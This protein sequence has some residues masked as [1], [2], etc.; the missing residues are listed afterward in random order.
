MKN[1][2]LL[3]K[4]MPF[5]LGHKA[6]IDFAAKQCDQLTVLVC[7][8]DQETMPGEL[9][10]QWIAETYVDQPQISVDL[11]HYKEAELPNSS[12]SSRTISK[13]W[14]HKLKILY[15][16]VNLFISSEPY[17]AYVAEY[18]GID[19]HVFDQDREQVPISA[20][21][22]RE[23][24]IQYWDFLPE[25]VKPHYHRKVVLLGTESTGKSTMAEKLAADFKQ[26][27]LRE[28]GRDLIPDSSDF[29]LEDLYRV[30]E[31]HQALLEAALAPLPALLIMDTDLHITQSY[32]QFSF[33][34]YL[35]LPEHYYA[36]QQAD[37]YLYLRMDVPFVQ[38]GSRMPE[39]DR[40]ALEAQHR[41]TIAHYQLPI[42]EIYGSWEAR[43]EQ[44]LAAIEKL[45]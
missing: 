34:Q 11:L 18:M 15:P 7:A 29:R 22:I 8:S 13:V 2:L 24:P 4:F 6:L 41:E 42:V 17:G 14:A 27:L 30:V 20:T 37:L 35:Y 33:G 39:A 21:K 31:A 38:D 3:G 26:P 16:E 23:N 28:A 9:R 36:T 45:Y 19:Y 5:H 40:A 43:W 12:E 32:A 44:A 10:Q 1:A 25:A